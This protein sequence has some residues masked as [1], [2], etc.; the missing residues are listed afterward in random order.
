MALKAVGTCLAHLPVG[1]KVRLVS[2]ASLWRYVMDTTAI[3]AILLKQLLSQAPF[4]VA[5][6]VGLIVTVLFWRRCPGPALLSLIAIV[7]QMLTTFGQALLVAY[8]AH[9][10]TLDWSSDQ[11]SW[12]FSISA[13]AGSGLRAV[14]FGLLLI[15]VFIGRKAAWP[16]RPSQ[17]FDVM[18]P[19]P[20]QAGNQGITRRPGW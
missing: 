2:S 9:R 16:S 17:P 18:E 14:S 7:L 11:I 15:A 6:F 5:Y 3:F 12:Y 10:D 19:A 13:F 1:V 4:L 8:L 20:T